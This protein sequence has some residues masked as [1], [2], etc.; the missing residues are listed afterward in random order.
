[1]DFMV[2]EGD[3]IAQLIIEKIA[4]IPITETNCLDKTDRG[5]AGFGSTGIT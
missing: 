2:N 5:D 3:H 4:T 1:M